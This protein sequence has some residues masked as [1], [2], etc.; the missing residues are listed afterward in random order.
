VQP[1]CLAAPHESTPKGSA[2]KASKNR[3]YRRIRADHTR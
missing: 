2:A 1:F 3:P